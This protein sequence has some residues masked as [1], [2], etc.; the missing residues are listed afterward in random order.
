MSWPFV[1]PA[2]ASSRGVPA[3]EE[4]RLGLRGRSQALGPAD[5]VQ[6]LAASDYPNR[7]RE[8]QADPGEQHVELEPHQHVATR[9]DEPPDR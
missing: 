2:A 6:A 1:A 3:L 7:H 5:A 4:I 9:H 8:L